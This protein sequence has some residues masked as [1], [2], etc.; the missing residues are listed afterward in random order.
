MLRFILL[1]VRSTSVAS[2]S[3]YSAASKSRAAKNEVMAIDRCKGAV[4]VRYQN[5][6][7]AREVGVETRHSPQTF[8]RAYEYATL[9]QR[10]MSHTHDFDFRVE[11]NGVLASFPPGF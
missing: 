2:V 5:R 9:H 6:S 7:T 8:A 1:K 11:K 4:R 3:K 10:L